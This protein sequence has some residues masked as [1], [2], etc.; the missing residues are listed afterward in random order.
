MSFSRYESRSQ[1]QNS[2]KAFQA[3]LGV[4]T[5]LDY[6]QTPAIKSY[7]DEEARIIISELPLRCRFLEVG[8]GVGRFIDLLVHVR[9][10][11]MITGV[12]HC[13]ELVEASQ[14]RFNKLSNVC[15]TGGDAT[16]LPAD[17]VS[18]FD[19]VAFTFNTLGNIEPPMDVRAVSEAKRVLCS[20]GKLFISVYSEHATKAQLDL[21]K[22]AEW[23]V[24]S[25]DESNKLIRLNNG[26]ISRRFKMDELS[27][28]IS[29]INSYDVDIIS[30]TGIAWLLVA[31][32]G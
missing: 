18:S 4:R 31:K 22:L 9:P 30:L 32:K 23:E 3:G 8:C 2:V 12:D 14:D 6:Y 5:Q 20:G 11:V 1:N 15:I 16:A 17:W 10:D 21:F 13:P 7:M 29:D 24:K 19:A 27:N 28:Y 26:W 25:L